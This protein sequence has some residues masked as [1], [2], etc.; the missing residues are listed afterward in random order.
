[1]QMENLQG[2]LGGGSVVV[3][4][5]F[6]VTPIEGLCICSM[7]YVLCLLYVHSSFAIILLGRES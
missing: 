3:D 5:L 2:S 7:F 4:F 1:M 6:I